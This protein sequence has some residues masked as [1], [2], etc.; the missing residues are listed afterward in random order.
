VE[1]S[2]PLHVTTVEL[3][4]LRPLAD[5]DGPFATVYLAT[6]P[7]IDNAAHRAEVRWRA[8]RDELG[9]AGAPPGALAAIDALVPD[10]HLSGGTLAAIAG[11]DRVHH[12]EHFEHVPRREL[13]RWAPLPALLPLIA[14]RQSEV[15]YVVVL[16]DRTGADVTAERARDRGVVREEAGGAPGPVR[17]SQPGGWSQRRYQQRAENTWEHNARDVADLVVG[18]ADEVGAA[19]VAVGG[20]VRA[21]ELLRRDL[22]DRVQ[23]LVVAI[24]ATR[25]ADGS[26]ADAS[27]PR[28][29]AHATA[30]Q[31]AEALQR[32]ATSPGLVADGAAATVAALQEARVGVLVVQADEDDERRAWFGRAATA[33][34]LGEDHARAAAG[35]GP[36]QAAALVDVAVRAALGTGAGIRVVPG[37]PP[38]DG[39]S[40]LL[41]WSEPPA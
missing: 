41:R 8:L 14:H 34:G 2:A 27:L 7:G 26:D 25:A 18:L 10:A 30:M 35:G 29:I 17:R 40:A 3:D 22:P 11:P 28:L 23:R 38:G 20:D 9:R 1:S 39:L 31:T 33:I 5:A 37:S 36:V 12:V 6:D 21:V 15:P 32:L 13:A 24:D 4:D 16:A 19:F